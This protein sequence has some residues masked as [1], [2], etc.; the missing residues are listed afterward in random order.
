MKPLNL[1][2]FGTV[3]LTGCAIPENDP[4]F[5]AEKS[6]AAAALAGEEPAPGDLPDR[7]REANEK[8]TKRLQEHDWRG[9]QP[10]VGPKP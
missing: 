3:L 4:S 5:R 7:V 8:N 2:I 9:V 10:A 1:F 6:P